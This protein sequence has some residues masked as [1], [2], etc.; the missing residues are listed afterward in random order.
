MPRGRSA[1]PARKGPGP[2]GRGGGRPYLG[3]LGGDR[4]DAQV[5]QPLRQ[6]LPQLRRRRHRRAAA[7]RSAAGGR[8]RRGEAAAAT[9][10]APSVG[11]R[12]PRARV[13]AEN[14]AGREPRCGSGAGLTPLLWKV[15]ARV[16]FSLRVGTGAR[17][18]SGQRGCQAGLDAGQRGAG[19]QPISWE[20]NAGTAAAAP[21]PPV[22]TRPRRAALPPSRG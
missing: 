12:L 16:G 15:V 13:G 6:R 21:P 4:G 19:P 2:A 11:E 22:Q 10:T 7:L 9:A 3:V 14:A 18:T 5:A 20:P 1:Q 17:F 8:E